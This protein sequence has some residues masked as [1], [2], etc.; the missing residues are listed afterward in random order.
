MRCR[1]SPV[2][3]PRSYRNLRRRPAKPALGNGRLQRQVR[4]AF[5]VCGPTVSASLV[6]EWARRWQRRHDRK[7]INQRERHSIR[8]VLLTIA[9]PITRASTRGRPWPWKWRNPD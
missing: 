1:P 2:M 9:D 6:Y 3:N 4:R 7:R 8:R 5:E